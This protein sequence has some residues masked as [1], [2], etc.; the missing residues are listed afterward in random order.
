[1][2]DKPSFCNVVSNLEI[3][4][5]G[6]ICDF[7]FGFS[8]FFHLYSRSLSKTNKQTRAS[9]WGRGGHFVAV[10]GGGFVCFSFIVF[11]FMPMR[12]GRGPGLTQ[13]VEI[14]KLVFSTP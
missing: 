6:K 14:L 13:W 11:F 4:Y 9:S 3:G 5:F 10:V 12:E 2:P 8:W 1:M 7:S